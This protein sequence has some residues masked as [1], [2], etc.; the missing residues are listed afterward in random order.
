MVD[1][2][3][4]RRLGMEKEGKALCASLKEELYD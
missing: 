2:K 3:R 4:A 1:G